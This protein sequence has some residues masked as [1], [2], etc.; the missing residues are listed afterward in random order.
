MVTVMSRTVV[1]AITTSACAGGETCGVYR[2]VV[3]AG[4]KVID[5]KFTAVFAGGFALHGGTSELRDDVRDGDTRAGGIL[6]GATERAARVLG[7]ERRGRRDDEKNS[8]QNEF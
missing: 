4:R 5:S 3:V 6:H 1:T 8:G 7:V 2:D